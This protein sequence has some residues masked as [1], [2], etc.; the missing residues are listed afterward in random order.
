MKKG[1]RKRGF[2]AY[3]KTIRDSPNKGRLV[4]DCKS[5][6]HLNS[7]DECTNNN[8]TA[9]DM[10]TEGDKTY[11]SFWQGFEYDNGRKKKDDEW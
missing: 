6:R 7:N 10:V 9:Y 3:R 8:V 5:C 2:N 11:C 1:E 4:A